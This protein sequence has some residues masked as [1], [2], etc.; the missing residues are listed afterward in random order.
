MLLRN[1][2]LKLLTKPEIIWTV[3]SIHVSETI[4]FAQETNV[5]VFPKILAPP[6]CACGAVLWIGQSYSVDL[7]W[8]QL[9][10]LSCNCQEESEYFSWL[11]QE[12][13]EL[14]ISC[15]H[16][17]LTDALKCA[18]AQKFK[19]DFRLRAVACDFSNGECLVGTICLDPVR[20]STLPQTYPPYQN[21]GPLRK[22]NH[23]FR[24]KAN[25]TFK[26]K[27]PFFYCQR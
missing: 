18:V 8:S 1:I 2:G 12:E 20:P 17:S 6:A 24:I 27:P 5:I 14:L 3:K 4:A 22:R 26:R 15:R 13:E 19:Q 25:V 7:S 10:A 21:L 11:S 9:I 16:H 23:C